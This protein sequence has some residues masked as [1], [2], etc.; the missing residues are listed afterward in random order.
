MFHISNIR[1]K[2]AVLGAALLTLIAGCSDA[3]SGLRPPM[4]G[5]LAQER[6]V[7]DVADQALV[8][9]TTLRPFMGERRQRRS[10]RGVDGQVLV[11]ESIVGV[12]GRPRA[13]VMSRNGAFLMRVNNEWGSDASGRLDRQQAYVLGPD[14]RLRS[15]DSRNVSAAELATARAKLRDEAVQMTRPPSGRNLGLAEEMGECDAQVNAANIAT[16]QYVTAAATVLAASATGNFLAAGIAYT[17]YLASYANYTSKQ[18]DLDK[19][20]ASIGKRPIY[21]EY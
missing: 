3:P 2:R 16:W 13:S 8:E 1:A 12:D 10:I 4:P 5:P 6:P 7:S 19:C 18:V 15:F 20:V 21:D 14:G 9:A 17:A 11:I